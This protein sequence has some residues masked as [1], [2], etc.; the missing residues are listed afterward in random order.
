LSDQRAF[1]ARF[2]EEHAGSEQTQL[3]LLVVFV[4]KTGL[5][6]L[7]GENGTPIA[8]ETGCVFGR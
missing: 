2:E 6:C 4:L 1:A 7:I 8:G 5:N 3:T